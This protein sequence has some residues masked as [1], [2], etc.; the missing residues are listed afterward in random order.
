MMNKMAADLNT[1]EKNLDTLTT[2]VVNSSV[3]DCLGFI[4]TK[5][6]NRGLSLFGH[7]YLDRQG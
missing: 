6:L 5:L 4:L 2:C 3:N 1:K 7:A